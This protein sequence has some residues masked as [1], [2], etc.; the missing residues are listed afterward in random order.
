M[1]VLVH[2]LKKFVC[3]FLAVLGLCCYGQASSGCSEQGLPLV[4]VCGLLI[5]GGTRASV[6]AAHG[7]RVVAE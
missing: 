7:T 2:V 4:A 5:T 1:N 3:L 6:V